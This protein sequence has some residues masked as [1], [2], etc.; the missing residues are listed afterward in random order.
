MTR[1]TTSATHRPM[2]DMLGG[3]FG[4]E[5]PAYNNF[6]YAEAPG[7]AWVNSGRAAFECLLH[8]MPRPQRVLVPRFVCDTLLE[9]LLSLELP[10][11]RYAI[12][13]QLEPLPP[14]DSNAG[15]LLVLVNYFGLNTPAVQATALRHPGPVVVDA[16]T[17]LYSPPLPGIPT[18]YSPRKFG[19]LCDGGI[20][21]APF[22]LTLPA[23]TDCSATRA[24]G[25][26]MRTEMGATAA[27]SLQ[28]AA[29]AEL[30]APARRMSPLTRRL[31]LATDWQ[32]GA[33]HRLANYATLHK[34]LAPINRLQLPATPPAA[35]MCYPLV[36]GIPGLR[37]ELIDAGIALP[38]Y[39]PE[40]IQN[41]E[42]NETENILA[43]TLLPLPLDQRYSTADMQ[44]IVR[45]ILG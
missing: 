18:F 20:A 15:D 37:D 13:E 40:V 1:M 6:P 42:A 9:P 28:Q 5:L 33:K 39:W 10:I 27:A 45:L 12:S 38:L 24:L 16:T 4:L 31:L 3:A 17:A 7:C 21:C 30:S 2:P 25:M 26:L 19:G 23:E 11:E 29:E 14:A 22:P 35:P 41:T 36:C 43:R 34:A 44:H 32:A 8:N